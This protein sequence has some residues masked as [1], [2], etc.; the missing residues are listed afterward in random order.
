VD[1][2]DNPDLAQ[3]YKAP[4]HPTLVITRPDGTAVRVLP[5]VSERSEIESAL[6]EALQ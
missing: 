3:Q 1:F 2:Y 4:G 6:K 5:G